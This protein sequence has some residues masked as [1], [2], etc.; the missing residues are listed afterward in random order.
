LQN[1]LASGNQLPCWSP[2]AHLGHNLRLSLMHARNVYLVLNLITM[3]VLPQYHCCFDDVFETICHSAP[4]VSGT[5]Y[6]QQLANLVCAKMVL[7]EVSVP[8]QPPPEGG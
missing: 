4:D 8:N 2:H 7:S 6:W 5:I 1:T 3:C